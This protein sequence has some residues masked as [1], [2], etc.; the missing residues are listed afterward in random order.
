[1][2]GNERFKLIKESPK[3]TFEIETFIGKNES[4]FKN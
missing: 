3:P 2:V 1:M 4:L